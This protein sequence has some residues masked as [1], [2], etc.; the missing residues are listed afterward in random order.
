MKTMMYFLISILFSTLGLFQQT[1]AM[2]CK[3]H[4][5]QNT[6]N[7]SHPNYSIPPQ[8]LTEK[9]LRDILIELSPP[10]DID[11]FERL[12][13]NPNLFS[14]ITK[15]PPTYL[16][17]GLRIFALWLTQ[18][19]IPNI[20]IHTLFKSE[21]WTKVSVQDKSS[22]IIVLITN[23]NSRYIF[24]N[25]ILRVFS[26]LVN[27]PNNFYKTSLW[28]AAYESQQ[29]QLLEYFLSLP[30]LNLNQINNNG[31]SVRDTL[32]KLPAE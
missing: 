10:D 19:E 5:A 8:S 3:Q 20:Y 30:Y 7:Y 15:T 28:F 2:E 27:I 17:E 16:N 31:I 6:P 29:R 24:D 26:T 21:L 18:T 14:F 13:E 1:Q 11:W 32:D 12:L 25:E 23:M 4:L 22:F 9:E